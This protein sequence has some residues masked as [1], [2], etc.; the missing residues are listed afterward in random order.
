M[1]RRGLF[2]RLGV[3]AAAVAVGAS[4]APQV[5]A[6]AEPKITV[7][8]HSYVAWTAVPALTFDDLVADC[9]ARG[10]NLERDYDILGLRHRYA[11]WLDGDRLADDTL[12]TA[13]TDLEPVAAW[14]DGL[15]ERIDRIHGEKLAA[16]VDEIAKNPG[17]EM[18]T[19][20]DFR[21]A[22]AMLNQWNDPA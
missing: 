5:E 1:N 20:D 3:A 13:D 11:H 22:R 6:G 19:M 7:N 16:A 14:L 12:T 21:K 4:V 10:C 8:T 2:K 9:K 15:H 18:L 17:G